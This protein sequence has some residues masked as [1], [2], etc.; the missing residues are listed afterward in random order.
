MDGLRWIDWVHVAGLFVAV[1]CFMA[2]A[3]S[4]MLHVRS[5]NGGFGKDE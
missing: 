2:L 4:M 1:V 3:A 5:G